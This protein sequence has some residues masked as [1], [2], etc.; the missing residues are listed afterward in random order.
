MDWTWFSNGFLMYLFFYLMMYDSER[1]LLT[2]FRQPRRRLSCAV[3][4][5]IPVQT[6]PLINHIG[7]WGWSYSR[8]VTQL[9][10]G[11]HCYLCLH[12]PY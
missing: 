9:R 5:G 8:H 2:A 11:W 12:R 3:C 6:L 10:Q 4:V 7:R 1:F